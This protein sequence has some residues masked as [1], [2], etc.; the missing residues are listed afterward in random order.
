MQCSGRG[1]GYAVTREKIQRLIVKYRRAGLV[2][3]D[4]HKYHDQAFIMGSHRDDIDDQLEEITNELSSVIDSLNNLM[5][6]ITS[7]RSCSTN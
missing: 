5:F 4:L 2:V 7:Y 1:A 3:N 6:F